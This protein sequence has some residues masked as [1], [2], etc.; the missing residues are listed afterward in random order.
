MEVGVEIEI[1]CPCCGK[2]FTYTGLVEIEPP[3]PNE[4]HY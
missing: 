4:G 3:E 2:T 1:E